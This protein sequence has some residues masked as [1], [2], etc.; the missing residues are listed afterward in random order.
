MDPFELE[1]TGIGSELQGV[2]RIGDG[3]VVFV[4]FA[5]PG[6]RVLAQ[7]GSEQSRYIEARAVKILSPAPE[8]VS[9]VCAHY[10][11]CGGCRT[12]HMSPAC[13][14]R[15]KRQIVTQQL[16]RIGHIIDPNVLPVVGSEEQTHYRNK[17]EFSVITGCNTDMPVIGMFS[18][19]GENILTVTD[20]LLQHPAVEETIHS[21]LSWMKQTHIPA[22]DRN[23]RKQGIRYVVTRINKQGQ[24]QVIL[25]TVGR[26]LPSCASLISSL[27][28]T[29]RADFVGLAH[30]I[31]NNRPSHALDGT[32]YSLYGAK[33]MRESICG[34]DFDIS[35]QTFLQVNSRQTDILYD[36]VE[37]AVSP[38]PKQG[39]FDAYCGC[40]TISLM[41]ARTCRKVIGV[42]LNSA[43]V[44]NAKHNAEINGLSKKASF[45]AA[46]AGKVVSEMLHKGN[47]PDALV[48]D[49]PRKGVDQ[50]LIRAMIE[51]RIPRIVYV[52][53]NTGTLAR[54]VRILTEGGYRLEWVQPVDMFPMTEHVET[55][56]LMSRKD[57]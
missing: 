1:I 25:S 2:G 15:L 50:K 21:V 8:R 39:V 37:K 56:V 32:M 27:C 36:I 22:S 52:S 45:I 29:H 24:I 6:E 19:G 23:G 14:L 7:P 3:R 35:P 34:L 5:L 55:V 54:D 13:A 57:T 51:A 31:L 53:C 11:S 42:E 44:V 4:P 17:A 43:A 18:E 10:E 40:G 20:C 9:P 38:S 48:V 33:T 49:P 28:T 26:I 47:I 41:L 12:Q 16:E 46:D 30:C